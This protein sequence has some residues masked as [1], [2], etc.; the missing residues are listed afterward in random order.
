MK[1]YFFLVKYEQ[2][3]RIFYLTLFFFNNVNENVSSSILVKNKNRRQ[4]EIFNLIDHGR[5]RADDENADYE[6]RQRSTRQ[7]TGH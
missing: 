5:H 3:N 1:K 4:F 7:P 2:I 6:Q